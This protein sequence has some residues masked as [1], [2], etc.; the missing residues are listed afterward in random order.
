MTMPE[1]Y[2][3]LSTPE[4]RANNIIKSLNADLRATAADLDAAQARI[5]AL[6]AENER[7]RKIEA[8][9]IDYLRGLQYAAVEFEKVQYIAALWE[10]V[11]PTKE[12]E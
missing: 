7:L 2:G 8:A 4:Q 1:P 12:A 10:A 3:I 5:A 6:E 11:Q 9:V